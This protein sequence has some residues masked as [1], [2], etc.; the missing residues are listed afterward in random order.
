LIQKL[1]LFGCFN[2]WKMKAILE[3]VLTS[4]FIR[5]FLSNL[6]EPI[7]LLN[8]MRDNLS[9]NLWNSFYLW[10]FD[11]SWCFILCKWIQ[12]FWQCFSQKRIFIEDQI[13]RKWFSLLN[14]KTPFENFFFQRSKIFDIFI[15]CC[16]F[17]FVW[18]D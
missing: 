18:A 2:D 16:F 12:L 9:L 14:F 10:P 6:M 17:V 3:V 1:D 7:N 8:Q 13:L 5:N 15:S 11:Q 4:H